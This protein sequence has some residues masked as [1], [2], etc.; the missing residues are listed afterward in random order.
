MENGK[1]PKNLL[2]CC[3]GS[4]ASVKCMELSK[5]LSCLF[6]LKVVLSKSA[7]H[8]AKIEELREMKVEVFID[9]DEWDSWK[10]M[11]DPVMHVEL[12]K[13]AEIVLVA[14]MSANS[15]GKFANGLSDNMI[16]ISTIQHS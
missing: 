11:G 4:V 5:R 2:L 3:T 8:F 13:W 10:K 1:Q 14:P 6:N 15:L 12:S 9:S 16:V 7:M